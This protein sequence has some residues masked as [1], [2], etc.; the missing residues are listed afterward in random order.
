MRSGEMPE[1]PMVSPEE[2]AT[3]RTDEMD[4]VLHLDKK[5]YKK[6][7]KIFL[8]EENAREAARFGGFGGGFPMGGP[9]GFE[10]GM[11][12]GGPGGF[13]GGMPPMGGPGGGF[14]GPGGGMPPMGDF[15]GMPGDFPGSPQKAT[16]NGKD[17]DSDEYID[18]REKK[19]QKI[20]TPEQ[21][22]HW[23][24]IHPDPSGFF[25]K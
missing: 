5:Q 3:Q 18:A 22:S 24:R 7:Y 10:G 21:Y 11:P 14:G 19:F 15:E 16:V 9:G 13:G 4:R 6:I 17:I 25:H 12:M 20:L 8:K 2:S 1:L 23:R